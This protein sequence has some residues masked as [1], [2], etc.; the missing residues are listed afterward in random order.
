MSNRCKSGREAESRQSP[1]KLL[2]FAPM[3]SL[4]TTTGGGSPT[5][6]QSARANRHP[7]FAA[8]I[9]QLLPIHLLEKSTPYATPDAQAGLFLGKGVVLRARPT[10]PKKT[11]PKNKAKNADSGPAPM[12]MEAAFF[13]RVPYA[14]PYAFRK[15]CW[16][17]VCV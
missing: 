9:P 4:Q 6:A 17:C 7:E 15:L 13:C 11:R 5:S 16:V 8:C 1:R 14:F 12:L 3:W 10:K 2:L